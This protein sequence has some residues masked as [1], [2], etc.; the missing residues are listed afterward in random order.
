MNKKN[1]LEPKIAAPFKVND[2]YFKAFSK[3]MLILVQQ[4][5]NEQI[6]EEVE[7]MPSLLKSKIEHPY[8]VPN[9]YFEQLPSQ[10]IAKVQTEKSQKIKFLKPL[11]LKKYANIAAVVC[12]VVLTGSY[13]LSTKNSNR[14]EAMSREQIASEL[15]NIDHVNL[16]TYLENNED[17]Y[18]GDH[19]IVLTANENDVYSTTLQ[20]LL[21]NTQ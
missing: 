1:L 17:L 21:D 7:T 18:Q 16:K 11:N 9:G 8:T 20:L 15:R 3:N 14:I 10:I 2:A 12:F 5:Q 6:N 4:Q 19:D 13:F